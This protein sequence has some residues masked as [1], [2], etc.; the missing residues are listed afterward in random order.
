MTED[1]SRRSQRTPDPKT[2]A[3][4]ARS[5]DDV[6]GKDEELSHA[7]RSVRFPSDQPSILSPTAGASSSL[8]HGSTVQSSEELC[9]SGDQR[10]SKDKS[11]SNLRGSSLHEGG[12]GGSQGGCGGTVLIAKSVPKL[13]HGRGPPG[14]AASQD[15]GGWGAAESGVGSGYR[16]TEAEKDEMGY[17]SE[18]LMETK[19]NPI[20]WASVQSSRDRTHSNPVSKNE[21][22][23]TEESAA[24]AVTFPNLTPL[25]ITPT[26]S[27]SSHCVMSVAPSPT[28]I[29][30]R[31]GSVSME[32]HKEPGVE[33]SA[34]AGADADDFELP[35]L[36]GRR[37]SQSSLWMNFRFLNPWST[38]WWMKQA[39]IN[40][41]FQYLEPPDS[42]LIDIA[43]RTQE[44]DPD[45]FQHAYSSFKSNVNSLK[46]L[47][48]AI[49]LETTSSVFLPTNRVRMGSAMADLLD[50]T[51]LLMVEALSWQSTHSTAPSLEPELKVVAQILVYAIDPGSGFQSPK[52]FK[53]SLKLFRTMCQCSGP[54]VRV[55]LSHDLPNKIA[56][57]L[58][59]PLISSFNVFQLVKTLV[60][61][62]DD[63]DVVSAFVKH[64]EKFGG[65]LFQKHI[66][67]LTLYG[68][69]AH[70]S[71]RIMRFVDILVRKVAV[72]E[73]CANLRQIAEQVL[74]P[75]VSTGIDN[76]D[77]SNP[78]PDRYSAEPASKQNVSQS[79]GDIRDVKANDGLAQA[80]TRINLNEGTHDQQAVKMEFQEHIDAEQARSLIDKA[81]R[82]LKTLIKAASYLRFSDGGSV[83]TESGEEDDSKSAASRILNF[84]Y[85]TQFDVIQSATLLIASPLLR[86]CSRSGPDL[87]T[88]VFKFVVTLL[89]R[90][91]GQLFLAKEARKPLSWLAQRPEFGKETGIFAIWARLFHIHP[92]SPVATPTE[93]STVHM[94][95][96]EEQIRCTPGLFD[97]LQFTW[98]PDEGA[99]IGTDPNDDDVQSLREIDISDADFRALRAAALA[100]S[101]GEFGPPISSSCLSMPLVDRQLIVL[102]SCHLYM[103]DIVERMLRLSDVTSTGE[104]KNDME[105]VEI[106]ERL[107]C[108]SLYPVGKHAVAAGL[109][110]LGAI[111]AL[112]KFISRHS[113]LL[114]GCSK[115]KDASFVD[116]LMTGTRIAVE[117]VTSTLQYPIGV[118][119]LLQNDVLRDELIS[120]IPQDICSSIRS[121][122]EPLAAFSKEGFDGVVRLVLNKHALQDLEDV[123]L[124]SKLVVT[125]RILMR[126]AYAEGGMVRLAKY[127]EDAEF[128]STNGV[129]TEVGLVTQLVTL[130]EL[131]STMLTKSVEP[132]VQSFEDP[133]AKECSSGCH[134]GG[135]SSQQVS[136][137]QDGKAANGGNVD[138]D[139]SA[140]CFDFV[141]TSFAAGSINSASSTPKASS[142][143]DL[144]NINASVVVV[145]SPELLCL[146]QALVE[147]LLLSVKLLRQVI[148]ACYDTGMRA[149]VSTPRLA[150]PAVEFVDDGTPVLISCERNSL[151]PHQ[152]PP[153]D[154]FPARRHGPLSSIPPTLLQLLYALERV[155]PNLNGFWPRDDFLSHHSLTRQGYFKQV[156]KTRDAVVGM[157]RMFTE[158]IIGDFPL[159]PYQVVV[160]PEPFKIGNS[161]FLSILPRYFVPL[162]H[163]V[164]EILESFT[165]TPDTALAG[166]ELLNEIL[167]STL[168]AIDSTP[169]A[170]PLVS[171]PGD[172][173]RDESSL[174]GLKKAV[175]PPRWKRDPLV[176]DYALLRVYWCKELMPVLPRFTD[177]IRTFGS[178][179]CRPVHYAVR[180]LLSRLV[181]LDI[182]SSG[183]AQALISI[184]LDEIE[185]VL[186]R[187][188]ERNVPS[189]LAEYVSGTTMDDV[190][191]DM[192]KDGDRNEVDVSQ[193][194]SP[195]VRDF[196]TNVDNTVVAEKHQSEIARW[197]SLLSEVTALDSGRAMLLR[198]NEKCDFVH[199][200]LLKVMHTIG[201]SCPACDFALEVLCNSH[202]EQAPGS[203]PI[204]ESHSEEMKKRTPNLS[205]TVRIVD[206]LLSLLTN[207]QD[208]RL[209]YQCACSITLLINNIF[210]WLDLAD[211]GQHVGSG[212]FGAI[213]T[214]FEQA[215][216]KYVQNA[217]IDLIYRLAL[218]LLRFLDTYPPSFP[219]EQ[220][221]MNM[222]QVVSSVLLPRIKL[223][224]TSSAAESPRS[225][226]VSYSFATQEH[227]LLVGDAYMHQS[228]ADIRRIDRSLVETTLELL[229]R[230]VKRLE[231]LDMAS[232]TM[233]RQNKDTSD[234]SSHLRSVGLEEQK[235]RQRS[236]DIQQ[237]RK[238]KQPTGGD[239][240]L[241]SS[242]WGLCSYV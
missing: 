132:V 68:A 118:S 146:R 13:F 100:D 177:L 228:D 161:D 75:H 204:V 111:P 163:L 213:C 173:K 238:R 40:S 222:L 165:H 52:L 53:T 77:V 234:V 133:D 26:S 188:T 229:R 3:A 71:L 59:H 215:L 72:Y 6:H 107:H 212:L 108:M 153:S 190:L 162:S 18:H 207:T 79:K 166:L 113:G 94:Q 203:T 124:L 154:P 183:L 195:E 99:A 112:S 226:A 47:L 218:L 130:I 78:S 127:I 209:R 4:A 15:N 176:S 44:S 102:L 38:D 221:R 175:A 30:Y 19:K 220:L 64:D 74:P 178:T 159:Q 39:E 189:T 196:E 41:S 46:E 155:D 62:L 206:S 80:E 211:D 139:I 31:S 179:T 184:V 48:G 236:E 9:V 11:V 28:P 67:P 86:L 95:N 117:L 144:S 205:H 109:I 90:R 225:R 70:S 49:R 36:Y 141:S 116:G 82:C 2:S 55:V 167:P 56:A 135:S 202:K 33:E 191:L 16:R 168:S 194:E 12:L 198:I 180:R 233:V 149:V 27:S 93:E 210:P 174:S 170:N 14:A 85:V 23:S 29:S 193:S 214:L 35:P 131:A 224:A 152:V 140:T 230:L 208:R 51:A 50:M 227:D 231:V 134:T 101:L 186:G 81:V 216:P 66:L 172:A 160:E 157:Y 24:E 121:C 122:F 103:V 164:R 21:Y 73:A 43:R 60:G 63:V 104:Q 69:G 129:L 145:F 17:W 97:L 197:L 83:S 20:E 171:K 57:I 114:S 76:K 158:G 123:D 199:N 125:L 5:D 143:S 235:V 10:I 110:L 7:D 185:K 84:Q 92:I 219:K 126:F 242:Y 22:T 115:P 232:S 91:N 37:G 142:L 65:S 181:D 169:T 151:E 25:V 148:I 182:E 192:S 58:S 156:A 120:V 54:A 136:P 98:V 147:L 89:G 87:L 8:G 200:V 45:R 61:C 96:A 119:Y 150:L 138:G 223:L 240:G 88:H 137:V 1:Y 42:N 217:E 128:V 32:I 34:M 187:I 239:H 241:S 105:M 237:S 201:F 106:L